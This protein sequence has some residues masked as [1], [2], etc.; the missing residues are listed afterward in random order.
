MGLVDR[1]NGLRRNSLLEE[2]SFNSPAALALG[3][4]RRPPTAACSAYSHTKLVGKGKP[5]EAGQVRAGASP[6]PIYFLGMA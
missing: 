5:F 1:R 4:R 2:A 6:A 3:G